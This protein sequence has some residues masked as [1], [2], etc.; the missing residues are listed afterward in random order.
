MPQIV[1]SVTGLFHPEEKIILKHI[2]SKKINNSGLFKRIELNGF[3][4]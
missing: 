1:S 4:P 3:N 2:F